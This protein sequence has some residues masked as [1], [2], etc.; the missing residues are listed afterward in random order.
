MALHLTYAELAE[1]IGRSE[2]AARSLAKRKR[3]RRLVGNDGIARITIDEPELV[4]LADPDR[5]TVGRPPANSTR[6]TTPSELSSIPDQTI[7][8]DLRAHLAAAQ[9][10]VIELR[11]DLDREREETRSERDRA[12]ALADRVADIATEMARAVAEA[13]DRERELHTRA[14]EAEAA[15]AE[16]HARPWWRRLVS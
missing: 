14:A 15:L 12:N 16:F 9:A 1:R 10:R 6:A 3:W 5:R 2:P 13:A 11:S 7:T 4:E 8:D